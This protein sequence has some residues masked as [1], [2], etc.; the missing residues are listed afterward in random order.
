[1]NRFALI[2]IVFAALIAGWAALIACLIR[3]ERAHCE[4]VCDHSLEDQ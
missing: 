4:T 3:M 1:M 2:G